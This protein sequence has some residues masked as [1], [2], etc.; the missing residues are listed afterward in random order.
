MNETL[1]YGPAPTSTEPVR[2]P[3]SWLLLGALAV[4]V[5]PIVG[6]LLGLGTQSAEPGTCDA[7]TGCTASAREQWTW[8]A[9]GWVQIGLWVAA[10]AVTAAYLAPWLRARAKVRK[11]ASIVALGFAVPVTALFAFLFVVI[12]GTDCSSGAFLCFGGPD[13]AFLVA[14]PGA[15]TALLVCLLAVGLRGDS[16]GAHRVATVTLT[17]IGAVVAATFASLLGSAV[18]AGVTEAVFL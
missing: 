17:G 2:R 7:W 16:R 11:V 15:V 6:F 10:A 8:E 14:S 3:P 12:L 18:L 9:G 13:D 4:A 5:L 1:G